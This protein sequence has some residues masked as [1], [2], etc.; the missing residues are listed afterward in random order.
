MK[1]LYPRPALPYLLKRKF[2]INRGS[3][4]E[5]FQHLIQIK[6]CWPTSAKQAD[7]AVTDQ[8]QDRTWEISSVLVFR[9]S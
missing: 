1:P 2:T 8:A 7:T 9:S 6:C 3:F 5:G 4:C